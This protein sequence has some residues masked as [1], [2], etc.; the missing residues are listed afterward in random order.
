MSVTQR[1]HGI[2]DTSIT[3]L[4]L[5]NLAPNRQ[6]HL[7]KKKITS[8]LNS[9]LRSVPMRNWKKVSRGVIQNKR[10]VIA[11]N[12]ITRLMEMF[13]CAVAG[14]ALPQSERAHP[15]MTSQATS[16]QIR[17]GSSA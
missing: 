11:V 6:R 1:N 7:K 15:I 9:L 17:R 3:S 5:L 16:Q 4:T 14:T 13:F 2:S 12:N 8:N 10:V